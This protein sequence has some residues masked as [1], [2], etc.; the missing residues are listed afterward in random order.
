VKI[1]QILPE[2]NEGGVE[3]GTVE[4]NREMVKCG[5]E[6]VVIS[7]GGL[8]AD[9]IAIDGGIHIP[10]DVC[11]KNPLT[12]LM[13]MYRLRRLLTSLQPDIIH[14]RSRVPAWLT[15]LANKKMKIPFI[16]TV[17]GLN[18]VN[19]YSE[20][21][22]FGDRVITVS[23]VVRDYIIKNYGVPIEKVR[24]IQR[25]ADISQ[26][27]PQKIDKDFIRTFIDQHNL[28][29]RYIVS[30]VGRVTWL[31]D[32]ETFIKSIAQLREHIP[33]ITGLIVGGT[34]EDKLGYLDSLKDLA[35]EH[36]VEKQII[37]TGS[38]KNIAEI[39]HLSDL[40][41]NASLKMGNIGR[42]VVE[43]LAMDTPVIATTY[44]GL[45]NLVVNDINGYLIEN[46][47][48]ADL[49]DKI[50]RAY[51]TEF[52][53]IREQLNPEYTLSTMVDKTLSVYR[54]LS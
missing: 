9:Q 28:G 29:G 48:P 40:V 13:R 36:G 8:Q 25:G 26:F 46:Q 16:T 37:F 10:F 6:S 17:H 33:N 2:L 14:V 11:S 30:S 38:Q 32:Y 53:G 20:V 47:N 34:R 7:A 54:E 18:S 3:R 51:S 35:K 23:E 39:Y 19:K 12:A 15:Y 24:V 41:V 49:V 42:T 21:M 4:L 52:T 5:I 31:K 50:L 22:T 44:E 1:V 27:D 43:A 45:N